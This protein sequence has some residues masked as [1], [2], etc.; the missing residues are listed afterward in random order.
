MLSHFLRSRRAALSP[1]DFSLPRDRRR[2]ALGLRRE[3]VAALAGISVSWYT[4]LE[5]GRDIRVSAEVLERLSHVL[6]LDADQREYLFALAHRRPAP[7]TPAQ[8]AA[9]YEASPLLWRSLEALTVPAFALTY[10]WDVVAWNKLILL[11]RDYSKL[12]PDSRNLLRL[13]VDD[14]IYRRD[15]SAYEKKVRIATARLRS[16]YG[17]FSED[18][19]LNALID[20]LSSK[21]PIFKRHWQESSRIGRA[22]GTNT[23]YHPRFGHLPFELSVYIPKGEPHLRVIVFLPSDLECA[24]KLELIKQG[25]T[26]H[27]AEEALSVNEDALPVN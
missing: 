7:L 19:I 26:E 25:K 4:W 10:R 14:P 8:P 6:Q 1:A 18:P 16:D 3:E 2:R 21:C 5:Q 13:L 17:Q 9:S 22:Y 12:R 27:S 11:F 15:M 23:I 20:E 24:E